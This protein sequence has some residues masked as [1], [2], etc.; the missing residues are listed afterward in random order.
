MIY[1]FLKLFGSNRFDVPV[2]YNSDTDWPT[3]CQKPLSFP[4]HV[5]DSLIPTS[6]HSVIVVFSIPDQ[7]SLL[8][9]P[10]EIDTTKS[11]FRWLVAGVAG[12]SPCLFGAPLGSGAV[13]LDSSSRVRGIYG[14]LGRDETDRLIM[15]TKI[16]N[17]Q[18]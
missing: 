14:V 13:L 1:F 15:E 6:G 16:L 11:S 8:R 4:F 2:M 18:Y 5:S 7:E 12:V 9:L 3:D 10:V 17:Q